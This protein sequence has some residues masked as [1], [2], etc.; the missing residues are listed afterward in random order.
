[1]IAAFGARVACGLGVLLAVGLAACGGTQAKAKAGT[2]ARAVSL[3]DDSKGSGGERCDA[4]KP[5]REQSEYDTTGDGVPDV[6]KVFLSIGSGG[7]TRLVTIC[8]ET[9]VNG[10]GK[11]DVIR[12]YDDEGRSLREEADRN[13]DGHMDQLVIYENG[14]IVR[15]EL[16]TNYDGKI[17]T[18]IFYEDGKPLRA[19]R[20]LS[21]HS[22]ATQWKPDRWEYYE[23]G[24]MVRMGTD[25][26]GDGRV[27]R[28]DRD[29]DFKS[30]EDKQ[31]AADTAAA[32]E[33]TAT[34]AA[35]SD[36]GAATGPQSANAT[37]KPAAAESA[38]KT[39][40]K[41]GQ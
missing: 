38:A 34:E 28:W 41:T 19:E 39:T 30:K 1:M 31:T 3:A 32:A 4:T 21:G 16:D 8:R 11:K 9:D 2:T 22:T 6:R 14:Q 5:G 24:K 35:P 13:F 26:N 18:K 20:D 15:E 25:L 29:L 27:D 37:T 12:Y 10:D 40:A 7:E 33:G 36:E 17:D 23:E